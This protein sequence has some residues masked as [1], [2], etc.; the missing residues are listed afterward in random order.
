MNRI[1]NV[2]CFAIEENSNIK[3]VFPVIERMKYFIKYSPQP[4][5]TPFFNIMTEKNKNSEQRQLDAY[6]RVIHEYVRFLNA[7]YKAFLIPQ[8][9]DYNDMRP[10]IWNKTKY[11]VLYSYYFPINRDNLSG[12][13]RRIRN[14]DAQEPI[15]IQDLNK[16]F[17]TINDAYRGKPPI[18]ESEFIALFTALQELHLIDIYENDESIVCLLKDGERKIIYEF[19]VGGQNSGV[20]IRDI[21]EADIY[22]DYIFDFQGANTRSIAR[23]KALFNPLLKQYFCIRKRI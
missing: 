2:K 17:G 4:P 23:Y 5:F 3:A 1:R 11:S 18:G 6:E 22:Q 12:I 7:K 20:L 9:Y 13:D 16:L 10:F 15:E 19:V 21:F 8:H 14:R